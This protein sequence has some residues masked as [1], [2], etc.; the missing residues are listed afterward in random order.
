[1]IPLDDIDKMPFGKHKGRMMQD[2][3][4]SY[5]H[6]LWQEGLRNETA[7]NSVADYIKRNMS[8]LKEE[9]ED[10]VWS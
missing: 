4:A 5:L 6:Y 10:G 9:Y 7:T 8:A 1:M 3:P 2:V